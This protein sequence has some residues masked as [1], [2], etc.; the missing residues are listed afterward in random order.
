MPR[1]I[2]YILLINLFYFFI[3]YILF[4]YVESKLKKPLA[5]IVTSIIYVTYF[6]IIIMFSTEF[7][8]ILDSS[9]N[10]ILGMILGFLA[11]SLSIEIYD[12]ILHK[13]QV[14]IIKRLF[15]KINPMLKD[16]DNLRTILLIL[17][18]LNAFAPGLLASYD[19]K[20]LVEGYIGS[21]EVKLDLNESIIN[22][23]NKVFILVTI[24]EGNYYLV[25]KCVPAPQ[26]SPVYAVPLN[27]VNVAKITRINSSN[28]SIRSQFGRYL[29]I[30]NWREPIAQINTSINHS[31]VSGH[32][33]SNSSL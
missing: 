3:C 11:R 26:V 22:L 27:K 8:N 32:K 25:E 17:L 23:S 9:I 33:L 4:F 24:Q 5:A 14:N 31:V 6:F 12:I 7:F 16:F 18:M 1:I 13:K 21:Y 15:D 19:A 29:S 28:Q 2:L 20:M 10:L 30:I